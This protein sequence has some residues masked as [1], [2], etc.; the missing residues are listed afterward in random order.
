MAFV[1]FSDSHYQYVKARIA[2]INPQRL[3]KGILNAQDWPPKNVTL[4]AF[5]L[6]VLNEA[7]MP[8]AGTPT[9]SA[10]QH[11]LQWVWIIQGRQIPVD[12]RQAN[13]GTAFRTNQLMK[14]ELNNALYP[15]FCEKKTW[16]AVN[17]VW[18]G[19]SLVPVEY[20]VWSS[21][22]YLDRQDKD[23]GLVYG[24]AQVTVAN[25]LDQTLS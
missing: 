13:R 19:A 23:S 24:A 11:N 6:L 16:S 8:G 12:A 9:V 7:P 20:I 4:E 25:M 14:G 1:D 5:Y 17:G 2:A 10:M 3:V 22:K 18:T 15:G 21:V